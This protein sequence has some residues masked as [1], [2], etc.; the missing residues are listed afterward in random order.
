MMEAKTLTT[1]NSHGDCEAEFDDVLHC[2]SRGEHEQK[3]REEKSFS[4]RSADHNRDGTAQRQKSV[5]AW[6]YGQRKTIGPEGQDAR[7]SRAE[8][9]HDHKGQAKQI[10]QNSNQ[11]TKLSKQAKC[12]RGSAL[13]KVDF[14]PW[15][16]ELSYHEGGLFSGVLTAI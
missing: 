12:L 16:S 5:S 14:V 11:L 3:S 7:G 8:K 6:K 1:K 13:G 2:E 10:V 4:R 9:Q 15:N